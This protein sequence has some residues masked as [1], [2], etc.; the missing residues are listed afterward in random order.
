MGNQVGR[1]AKTYLNTGTHA[2]ATLVEAKKFV[3]VKLPFSKGEVALGDRE[4]DWK[5]FLAGL[6][7]V[8]LNGTYNKKKQTTDAVYNALADSFF[9]D[10]PIEIYCLDGASTESGTYGFRAYMQVFKFEKVEDLESVANWS[11]GLKLTD[12]EE[13]GAP[14]EPDEWTAP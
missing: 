8:G 12:Y 9:N 5:K 2:S 13:A 3:D 1:T 11:V 10:T 14:V 6:K 7:E 4:S